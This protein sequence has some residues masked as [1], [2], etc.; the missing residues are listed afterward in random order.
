MTDP[1]SAARDTAQHTA[2]D[3]ACDSA[4]RVS[5]PPADAAAPDVTAQTLAAYWAE[6]AGPR[7]VRDSARH[8]AE[9]APMLAAMLTAAGP[10]PGERVVD[11]GCGA[12]T[13]TIAVAELV[14]ATGRVVGV[15]VSPPLVAEMERRVAAATTA[16]PE[17]QI[18]T[19][20]ANAQ[21]A[22]LPGPFDLLVSRFGVMF[23]ADQVVA[24]RNMRRA[25]APDGRAVV[26]VW[27]GPS[28]NLWLTAPVNAALAV[29]PAPE[30][31]IA[32]GAPGAE[33]MA[34]PAVTR[35]R[36]AA[37][38]WRDVGFQD[39]RPMIDLGADIDRAIDNV[40]SLPSVAG[41]IER[42]GADRVLQAVRAS[43]DPYVA[44]DGV[45]RM[46]AA[47]WVVTARA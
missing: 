47:A 5:P 14:G 18:E 24:W 9:L 1:T 3:S 46:Q 12:G 28:A 4:I 38:G 7:W 19:L 40:R 25:M 45:V 34:D 16:S 41:A 31:P 30:P 17:L 6:E 35:Q 8:D 36:L 2:R 26:I 13:S 44:S 20:L 15:D 42:A 33:A 21:D 11:I 23:F 43:L 39:L 10:Q 37:A 27:Q 22:A 32:P 29:S